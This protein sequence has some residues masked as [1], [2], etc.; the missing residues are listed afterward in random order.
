MQWNDTP[1][2]KHGCGEVATL[3]IL[4]VLLVLL[5]IWSL[6]GPVG[7]QETPP[8]LPTMS[9][10]AWVATPTPIIAAP[11]IYTEFQYLPVIHNGIVVVGA[12]PDHATVDSAMIGE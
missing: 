11:I 3:L 7:A 4:S 10:T 12:G 8:P 6:T 2:R 5:S 9:S 1:K